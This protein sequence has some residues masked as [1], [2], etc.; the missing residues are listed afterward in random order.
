[1]YRYE[2]TSTVRSDIEGVIGK[3]IFYDDLGTWYI[4]SPNHTKSFQY[5]DSGTDSWKS[6]TLDQICQTLYSSD[7]SANSTQH[8]YVHTE[9]VQLKNVTKS[10]SV[11]K[12]A[13]AKRD[14]DDFIAIVSHEWT[15]KT[16]WF[17]NSTRV[18][19]ETLTQ[20]GLEYTAANDYWID[21]TS[22]NVPSEDDY[23]PL[24]AA[25]IYDNGTEVTSGIT[26]DYALG[27]VTFDSAPTGPVT[28]DY[29]Y[30]GDSTWIVQPSAGK[31][32]NI[33]HAELDFT[34]DATVHDVSFEIWAYDPL[35]L[36]NKK[37]YSRRLYKNIKDVVKI[38]NAIE[39]I[40]E[41]GGIGD[42]IVRAVFDY[43][44]IIEL[45]SSEGTELRIKI[46]DDVPFSG[47][48]SSCTIYTTIEDE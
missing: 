21:L 10:K 28:A 8:D 26:I 31:I 33:E 4:D 36:P 45:K 19:G 13:I 18:T 15:D 32:I 39:V 20:N 6:E 48:F 34:A 40:D 7:F 42:K 25:K 46:E 30:A 2:V 22:G 17:S 47:V 14:G 37:M 23:L 44:E 29:S 24:Y 9:T 41:L 35:D 1:M 5:F 3:P 43:A 11:P 38:A 27:K 16:T 12:V